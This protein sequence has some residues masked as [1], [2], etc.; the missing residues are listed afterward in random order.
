MVPRPSSRNQPPPVA[1]VTP[2][3]AKKAKVAKAS[4]GRR[5]VELTEDDRFHNHTRFMEVETIE[6]D[7]HLPD[8][9]NEIDPIWSDENFVWGEPDA[10]YA[11]D[12]AYIELPARLASLCWG[13]MESLEEKLFDKI[14]NCCGGGNQVNLGENNTTGA[15][16]PLFA[17]NEPTGDPEE[18][19][20]RVRAAL[21]RLAKLIRFALSDLGP[22]EAATTMGLYRR[23]WTEGFAWHGRKEHPAEVC[24]NR[25]LYHELVACT[26]RGDDPARL[27]V[28][29][30]SLAATLVHE[31][32]HA[33]TFRH[34][35]GIGRE[36]YNEVFVTADA[37]VS[38]LAE[39]GIEAE[40]RLF[41]G[42][43]ELFQNAHRDV[44]RYRYADG[45]MSKQRGI[46]VAWT[47]PYNHVW[48]H[49]AASGHPI[50]TRANIEEVIPK[51]DLA[52]RV[53]LDDVAKLFRKSTWEGIRVPLHPVP[54]RGY[55][56]LKDKKNV[57]R[58]Q[59]VPSR[60]RVP[61]ELRT[62]ESGD[63]VLDESVDESQGE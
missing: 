9:E 27:L 35:T 48:Q 28:L 41:G 38:P 1:E 24:L 19:K 20:E 3:A 39:I 63:L 7:F 11:I 5:R 46:L 40:W 23:E 10:E 51:G 21:A 62:L 58:H 8:L 2:P 53:D 34:W 25:A 47:W 37:A 32:T 26:D 17:Y 15:S 4:R 42:M 12:Y 33:L 16:R 59:R 60:G 49:Y 13:A 50:N 52:W 31:T 30:W 36:L 6:R 45:G 44:F 22:S 56:F 55:Y 14:V 54:K 18:R 43:S 57:L 61:A 29:Q